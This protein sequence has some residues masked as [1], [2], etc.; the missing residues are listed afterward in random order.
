MYK[1]YMLIHGKDFRYIVNRKTDDN[2][3]VYYELLRATF[4]I[5]SER[6]LL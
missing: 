2:I 3:I 4:S 1:L 5:E 6:K